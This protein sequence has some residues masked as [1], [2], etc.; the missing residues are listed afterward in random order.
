MKK[1]LLMAAMSIILSACGGQ[2]T[3]KPLSICMQPGDRIVAIQG[4]D[5]MSQPVREADPVRSVAIQA[6]LPGPV[7]LWA[8]RKQEMAQAVANFP[9]L[10]AE[11]KKYPGKFPMVYLYDEAGWCNTGLCW[12]DHEDT[13]LQGAALAK[14]NGMGSLITILPDVI[15]DSH[16]KMKDINAFAGISIDVY[17]SIRPTVPDFKGCKFSDNHL[18]NLFYCSAQ[19]LRAHGFTGKI[20]YI[21]QGFGLT[22]DTP[23]QRTAYL[24]QQRQAINN[25]SAMGADAVM[26]WGCHLGAIELAEEPV[27]VP[28]CGTQYEGLATP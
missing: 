27:L 19:K 18:E 22:T 8:G 10:I 17:P 14:A 1:T 2:V 24:T 5:A 21:F 28:L 25:A 3:A 13:V 16:F 23:D 26:S 7:V 4:C 9:T 15:L 11:S 12:F 6:Q 20:G